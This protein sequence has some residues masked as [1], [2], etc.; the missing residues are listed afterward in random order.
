MADQ[1][2][3]I[4]VTGAVG[5]IGFQ[6][7][8]A[9][10][11]RHGDGNVVAVG[12]ITEPSATLRDGRPYTT[13]DVRD[14]PALRRIIDRYRIDTI[15]HLAA[16]PPAVAER[17]P[18]LAW[19]VNVDGLR[20]VLEVARDRGVSR[21]F[22]PSSIAVFGPDVPKA[23]TPQD[24]PCRP[25]TV[26]GMTKLVGETL[27]QQY[28]REYDLDVRGLRYPPIVSCEMPLR[29]GVTDY[30]VEIFYAAEAAGHY[31]C[32]VREDTVVPVMY[33]PDCLRAALDLM[34]A[35][36]GSLSTSSF[37]NVGGASFSV[38]ELAAEIRGHLPGFACSF[39]PDGRQAIADGLPRGIDDAPARRDWNWKPQYGLQEIVADMLQCVSGVSRPERQARARK[40]TPFSRELLPNP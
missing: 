20:N 18:R 33:L 19:D 14:A 11:R 22:V 8:L 16:V 21:V 28:V 27:A 10:R 25:R 35:E 12:H 34:E 40:Y 9:L 7:T 6:L 2:R 23:A 1:D 37:Y 24:A 39:T 15:Y 4:L 29:G 3:S 31:Q 17:N 5:Q 30:A 36:S 26:Y 32:F 13:C 38:G